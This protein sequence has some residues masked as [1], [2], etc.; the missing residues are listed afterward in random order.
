MVTKDPETGHAQAQPWDTV[1]ASWPH[2][3]PSRALQLSPGAFSPSPRPMHLLFSFH[4]IPFPIQQATP[5]SFLPMSKGWERSF[6]G[7]VEAG[8]VGGS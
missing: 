4:L 6:G 7:W 8:L 5:P 1:L 3:S 2:L